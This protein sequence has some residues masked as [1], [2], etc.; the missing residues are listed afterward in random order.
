M[1]TNTAHTQQPEHAKTVFPPFNRDTFASQL[2]W[3]ALTFIVLYL[4]MSRIALPRIAGIFKDRSERIAG[5]LGEAQ[6]MKDDS[7]AALA[8]YEK[9]LADA[10]GRAHTIA[11]ET[12]DKLNA[13]AEEQRKGLEATLNVKLAE[14]EQAIARTR[15]A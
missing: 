8:A 11:G 12:R 2:V 3:L 10:R 6:R 1:A 7:E 13:E 5:D 14:S 4:L 9:A 15:S